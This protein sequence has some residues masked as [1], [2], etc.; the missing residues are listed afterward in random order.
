VEED[1]DRQDLDG[2]QEEGRM[3]SLRKITRR[4][5]RTSMKMNTLNWK[6]E[7]F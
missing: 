4:L 6:R 3:V 7:K 2:E 5:A 1:D